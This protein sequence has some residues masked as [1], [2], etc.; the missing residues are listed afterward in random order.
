MK[1]VKKICALVLSTALITSMSTSAFALGNIKYTDEEFADLLSKI[2]AE[3]G[4]DIQVMS[5]SDCTKYDITDFQPRA[6]FEHGD[7]EETLRYI[8]EVMIP[9]FD[10]ATQ[11]ADAAFELVSH[12]TNDAAG[13]E[14]F[15]A[16]LNDMSSEFEMS[17]LN[18]DRP[19][20]VAAEKEIKYAT[21]TA[22]AYVEKDNYGNT[23]WG[24]V[25]AKG[26]DSDPQSGEFWF[27]A[28]PEDITVTHADG[29]RTLM[30]KGEGVYWCFLNGE[31]CKVKTGKQTAEMYISN[32]V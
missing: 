9:Q 16:A 23:V 5:E 25:T 27:V 19:I 32:Y 7:L 6:D 17:T 20:I 29:R 3:Y 22:S 24:S 12:E 21:A 8:A 10:C 2:N 1:S 11:E 30:W 31:K 4:T 15:S 14:S 18:N 13:N 28:Q 26:C